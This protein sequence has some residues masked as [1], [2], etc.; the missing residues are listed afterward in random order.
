[1]SRLKIITVP[2]ILVFILALTGCLMNQEQSDDGG[3]P[4]LEQGERIRPTVQI[5][6]RYYAGLAPMQ[7]SPT[8]TLLAERLAGNRLDR[9]RFEL[10]LLELAQNYFSTEDHLFAGGQ[11]IS[12]QEGRN[13]L[14]QESPTTPEGLNPPDAP[15]TVLKQIL[16]HNYYASN[17]QELK[18]VVVGL[19]LASTY[20]EQRDNNTEQTLYYTADQLR[21]YGYAMAE[22]VV[23]RLRAKGA[24]VPIVVALYQLE[25]V[26]TYRPGNFLSVG[27]AEAGQT[28]SNW[29]TINEVYML[30]P[31][32]ALERLNSE[33]AQSFN[34]LVQDVDDFFPRYV[35]LVGTGRFID[36]QLSEL[37]LKATTEF[38]SIAEVI[39]LTQFI[40]A[41]AMEVFSDEIYLALY[42][43]SIN[44][45]KAVFVRP[46]GQE[47]IIHFYR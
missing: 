20:K 5:E 36:E 33:L 19:A 18:G 7:E 38:A 17:G 47:P 44:E 4:S 37:E 26:D 43:S 39:Q 42:V 29:E 3:G 15:S 2:M 11:L 6:E 40:G 10:G 23:E 14:A 35:G 16:E 32:Q 34:T 28:I 13:W 8:R 45:P 22:K 41:E 46:P 30:F 25:E 1:M 24:D 12:E 31:S 21:T 27:V 9:D